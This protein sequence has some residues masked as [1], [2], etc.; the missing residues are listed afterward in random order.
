MKPQETVLVVFSN[1]TPEFLE[2]LSDAHKW[3]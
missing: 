1:Y 2:R 3:Q